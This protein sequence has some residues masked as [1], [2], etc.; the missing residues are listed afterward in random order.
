MPDC[1]FP[2]IVLLFIV[3]EALSVTTMPCVVLIRTE[4]FLSRTPVI[5]PEIV[6]PVLLLSNTELW[7]SI[8]DDL[9]A[10]PALEKFVIFKSKTLLASL[11]VSKVSPSVVGPAEVPVRFTIFPSE[12]LPLIVIGRVIESSVE[13]S[14]IVETELSKDTITN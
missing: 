7:T 9:R 10:S 14:E 5:L 12:V 2:E 1:K 4:L 6:M 8:F 13:A 3:A 11:P